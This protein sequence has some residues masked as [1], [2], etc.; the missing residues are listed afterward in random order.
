MSRTSSATA[1]ERTPAR[2][3]GPQI[4]LILGFLSWG[5]GGAE[6]RG[7]SSP[8]LCFLR[9]SFFLLQGHSFPSSLF[10]WP[11]PSFT[12]RSRRVFRGLNFDFFPDEFCSYTPAPPPPAAR[13][14]SSLSQLLHLLPESFH[15]SKAP[16]CPLCDI[17]WILSPFFAQPMR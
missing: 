2:V 3:P 10:L 15:L 16:P 9:D 8:T 4:S 14:S 11:P 17:T 13:D 12:P 1:R 7:A 6:V 5:D